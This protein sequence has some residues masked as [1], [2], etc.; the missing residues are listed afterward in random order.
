MFGQFSGRECPQ[1]ST[2]RYV[3]Y[4]R[5]RS[6]KVVQ[7]GR[8]L[9]PISN[10]KLRSAERIVIEKLTSRLS[11]VGRSGTFT[12]TLIE[13]KSAA[14]SWTRDGRLIQDSGRIQVLNTKRSSMLSIDEIETTD[15]GNYTCIATNNFSEDR[16]SASLEVEGL[17]LVH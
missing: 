2:M 10:F 5:F 6:S 17:P 12:C 8:N 11:K 3:L 1:R 15:A 13:G 9:I 4:I 16:S 7:G 14:F